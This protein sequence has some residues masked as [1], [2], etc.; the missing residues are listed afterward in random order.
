M[1]CYSSKK[2]KKEKEKKVWEMEG[3]FDPLVMG[4]LLFDPFLWLR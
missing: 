3:K 4:L 2:K 1:E